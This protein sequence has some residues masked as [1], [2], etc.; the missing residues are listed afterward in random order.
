[1]DSFNRKLVFI[2]IIAI[3]IPLSS[4]CNTSQTSDEKFIYLDY[5]TNQIAQIFT[6]TIGESEADQLTNSPTD[7]LEYALTKDGSQI[8]FVVK[9]GNGGQSIWVMNTNGKSQQKIRNCPTSTCNRLEWHPDGQRVLYEK[10]PFSAQTRPT[11]WWIDVTNG[12]TTTVLTNP[13]EVSSGTAV[14]PDGK[15]L[16]YVSLPTES[17]QFVNFETGDRFSIP[18]T[19]DTPAAWHP[20]SQDTIIRDLNIVTY[21]AAE[22]T[23]HTEHDHDF[24]ESIHLFTSNITIQTRQILDE[25][26]NVDD[27]NAAWSPDGEW[28]AFGRKISRTNTGRQLWLMRGDGSDAKALTEDLQIQHGP[29]RWSENGRYLLFQKANLTDQEPKPTIWR[30]DL[31]TNQAEQVTASGWFPSWLP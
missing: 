27:S 15:W 11:I 16:S 17:I 20:N 8:A 31:E 19:I 9:E 13:N 28:I 3:F 7:I 12:E 25:T 6:L 30:Y 10:R 1:M 2:L 24:A 23:D 14:S 4:A 21:H 22:G 26:G 29:P 5:D 18:S